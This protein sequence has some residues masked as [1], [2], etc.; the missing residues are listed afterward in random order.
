MTFGKAI[1]KKEPH[2]I[3][4]LGDL[5][6]AAARPVVTVFPRLGECADCAER[7]RRWNEAV[8]F[9]PWGL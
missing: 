2:K 7:R 5:V 1:R 6:H 9:G 3:R 8:P 4:G